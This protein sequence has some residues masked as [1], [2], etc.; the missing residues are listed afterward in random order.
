MNAGERRLVHQNSA[1]WNQVASWLKRLDALRVAHEAWLVDAD[2]VHES[3]FQAVV[4]SADLL[5]AYSRVRSSPPWR[6]GVPAALHAALELR[7]VVDGDEFQHMV[8]VIRFFLV[9]R[10]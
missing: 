2:V 1:S 3:I 4:V 9:E 10:T 6:P 8:A 5:D 7:L